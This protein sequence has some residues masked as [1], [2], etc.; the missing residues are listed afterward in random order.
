MTVG[1]VC[2]IVVLVVVHVVG[3]AMGTLEMDVCSGVVGLFVLVAVGIFIGGLFCLVVGFQVG[4]RVGVKAGLFVVGLEVGRKV[5]ARAGDCV[6][7]GMI[8]ALVIGVGIGMAVGSGVGVLV[9][10]FTG[11][12]GS[13]VMG[14]WV[15]RPV[16]CI[17]GWQS[18]GA[19]EMA[20]TKCGV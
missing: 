4:D 8:G 9:V 1:K 3:G 15:G 20:L 6:V 10:C 17:V 7:L 12:S 5:W 19:W 14:V 2:G 16:V 11:W 13:F 18:I